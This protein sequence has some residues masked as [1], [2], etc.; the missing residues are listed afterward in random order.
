MKSWTILILHLMFIISSCDKSSD[1]SDPGGSG[2]IALVK[3]ISTDNNG[4]DD[5]INEFSY[6][7]QGREIVQRVS[8]TGS[9]SSLNYRIE[10]EYKSNELLQKKYDKANTLVESNHY[11]LNSKNLIDSSIE[12]NGS[13]RSSYLYNNENY[14]VLQKS[15]DVLNRLVET[16][17]INYSNGSIIS[18]IITTN[19]GLGDSIT[20]YSEF[21][22]GKKNT[23]RNENFGQSYRGKN[24]TL[25]AK[26][27]K[28]SNTQGTTEFQYFPSY[29]SMGR[30]TNVVSRS[31]SIL[32]FS[33]EI[34]YY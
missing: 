24:S 28:I 33:N 11:F 16:K 1:D 6:D 17:V 18:Q 21:E 32:L 27:V 9:S 14:L 2:N 20:E 8:F 26:K 4:I 34:S 15:Y 5:F 13:L 12:N 30:I 10:S 7:A 3:S 25:Y 22:T 29:D 19:S 31:Q 23:L